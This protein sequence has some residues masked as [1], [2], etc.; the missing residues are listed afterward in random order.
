MPTTEYTHDDEDIVSLVFRVDFTLDDRGNLGAIDGLTL[1]EV[2]ILAGKTTHN[3]FPDG[4]PP[5]LAYYWEDRVEQ[6]YDSEIAESV[7][8]D[9]EAARIAEHERL[10]KLAMENRR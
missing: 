8:K 3:A 2:H 4:I 5:D 10:A 7:E 9:I 6:M 1:T